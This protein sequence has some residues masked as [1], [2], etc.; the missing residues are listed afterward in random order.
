M[1]SRH[2]FVHRY[3]FIVNLDVDEVIVP[4]NPKDNTWRDLLKY[5]NRHYAGF[6]PKHAFLLSQG[7]PPVPDVPEHLYML[8][9][10]Q[11][12]R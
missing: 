10:I 6:R 7:L 12:N 2:C 8:Q 11:V 4:T 9:T 5:F 3:Q 1:A